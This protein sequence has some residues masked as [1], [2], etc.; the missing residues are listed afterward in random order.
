[1]AAC[2]ICSAFNISNKWMYILTN[3]LCP[4]SEDPSKSHLGG[5]WQS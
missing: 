1:M 5:V 3:N 2:T 4:V